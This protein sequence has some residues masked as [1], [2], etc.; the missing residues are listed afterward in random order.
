MKCLTNL[1]YKPK[2]SLPNDKDIW[3][4]I[5]KQI[6]L[7]NNMF[8]FSEILQIFFLSLSMTNVNLIVVLQV[9]GKKK[10]L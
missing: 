9:I 7:G 5:S 4:H 1:W 2:P 10:K 3:E 6:Q 8:R